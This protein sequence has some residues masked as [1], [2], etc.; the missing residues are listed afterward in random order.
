MSPQQKT[1]T[2]PD[3][4]KKLAP[5]I[6]LTPETPSLIPDTMEMLNSLNS[7]RG[8]R[9]NLH[10]NRNVSKTNHNRNASQT[11]ALKKLKKEKEKVLKDPG[12]LPEGDWDNRRILKTWIE[13]G[14]DGKMRKY[15]RYVHRSSS[16]GR[17]RSSVNNGGNNDGND[18]DGNTNNAESSSS[19]INGTDHS[20]VKRRRKRAHRRES[21]ARLQSAADSLFDEPN[22]NDS[23]NNANNVNNS[24][25]MTLRRIKRRRRDLSSGLS[26]NSNE[27][28]TPLRGT[29]TI[30]PLRS[31]T[32]R[33]RRWTNGTILKSYNKS[34][35]EA[36]NYFLTITKFSNGTTK[37]IYRLH[38]HNKTVIHGRKQNVWRCMGKKENKTCHFVQPWE[39]SRGNYVIVS[40]PRKGPSNLIDV[41]LFSNPLF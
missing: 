24:N 19:N 23:E 13:K 40:R 33:H 39:V 22:G 30:P 32:R 7:S 38:D 21:L 3:K 6:F 14:P 17:R 9:R 35:G 26:R 29:T 25:N 31:R 41:P 8:S 18:N 10:R 15:I 28:T 16:Y 5:L 34:D 2:V 4:D 37:T 12:L 1:E 11:K 27:T 20:G 36:S